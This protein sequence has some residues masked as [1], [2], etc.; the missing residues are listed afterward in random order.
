[1]SAVLG[2]H[3][4]E[5]EGDGRKA[6]RSMDQLEKTSARAARNIDANVSGGFRRAETRGTASLAVLNRG[7][8]GNVIAS[9][10]LGLALAG[11]PISNVVRLGAAFGGVGLAIGAALGAAIKLSTVLGTDYKQTLG[12]PLKNV[13]RRAAANWLD[14]LG[15]A[16]VGGPMTFSGMLDPIARGSKVPDSVD[17]RSKINALQI[18]RAELLH[19]RA[20]VAQLTKEKDVLVATELRLAKIKPEYVEMIMQETRQTRDLAESIK[21]RTQALHEDTQIANLQKQMAELSGDASASAG[22]QSRLDQLAMEL[23]TLQGVTPGT[24]AQLQQLTAT[25]RVLEEE[26]RSAGVFM[27]QADIGRQIL[28]TL[29]QTEAIRRE[30]EIQ[31]ERERAM[32]IAQQSLTPDERGDLLAQSH[33]LTLARL[34]ELNIEYGKDWEGLL[35]K[36]VA[37]YGDRGR[38]LVTLTEG[39]VEA[40]NSLFE[41]VFFDVI[42]GNLEDLDDA[43]KAFFKNIAREIANMLARQATAAILSK[44]LGSAIIGA[45]GGGVFQGGFRAF[46]SGGTVDRPTL[47]LVGEGRYNEAVVPLPDGSSIPVVMK[48]DSQRPL[49]AHFTIALAA[50]GAR[51]SDEQIIAASVADLR[52]NGPLRRTV[53]ATCR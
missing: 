38:N 25:L 52:R 41:D 50:E 9:R 33:E 14:M 11:L 3:I 47:G 53:I 18:E 8:N 51:I 10:G 39:T 6:L 23:L 28:G 13:Q 16:A 31:A 19:N 49:T 1:M 4:I 21:L 15:N 29:P 20:A 24:I 2:T 5:F 27:A 44:V 34:R 32:G 43:F 35:D 48:G 26:R 37:Q 42:T 17:V 46:A 22:A 40:M 45:A 7:I 30:I 36:M 12:D